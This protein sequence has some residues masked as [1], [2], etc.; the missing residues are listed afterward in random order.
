MP[1]NREIDELSGVDTTGHE[2]DGIKELNNPL[3]RWWL[4]TLYA[5]IVWSL[6]YIVVYPALPGLSSNSK[7]IWQWSSRADLRT[8]LTSVEQGRQT[9]G[10]RIVRMD[11][12]A[13][14]ADEEVRAFAA[15]AG[16]STFK[17]NCVQCH[18]SGAQGGPGYPNL[19]DDSWLWGGTPEQILQTIAHGV[20]DANNPDTRQSE[21]PA[22]GRDNLLDATQQDAVANHVRKI[23]NMEHDASKAASGAQLYIDN[24]AACHGENG[25]G[26]MEQGGPQLND[27]IWLYGSTP[28]E[29]A[30]QIH[31]PRHGMMPAWQSRL[32]ESAVKQ[33]AT[34]VISLG[35]AQ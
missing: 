16:A 30:L 26:N 4:W 34:Y 6:G 23:A 22:F 12:K 25:E 1:G 8:E 32:G 13:I 5:T 17:V 7:G 31:T 15:A 28:E 11:I 10:A 29:I 20:R 18:A 3:P 14:I 33:L 2:W 21:M 9:M 27:A 24:C 19:N 35:G